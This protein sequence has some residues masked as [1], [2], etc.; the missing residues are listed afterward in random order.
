MRGRACSRLKPG[1]ASD[2][3]R[4]A[5]AGVPGI[6]VRANRPRSQAAGPEAMPGALSLSEPFRDRLGEERFRGRACTQRSFLRR[7]RRRSRGRAAPRRAP[8]RRFPLPRVHRPDRRSPQPGQGATGQQALPRGPGTR[9]RHLDRRG[10]PDEPRVEARASQRCKSLDHLNPF[11]DID[12]LE[13]EV[14]NQSTPSTG[15][16]RLFTFHRSR[17]V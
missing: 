8:S 10:G 14:A 4:C 13:R 6:V 15:T 7:P 3:I 9:I 1:L 17:S 5:R 11:G 2:P 12:P 16:S